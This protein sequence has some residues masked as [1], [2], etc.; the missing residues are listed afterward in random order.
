MANTASSYELFSLMIESNPVISNTSTTLTLAGTWHNDPEVW[1]TSVSAPPPASS[2]TIL[3][4]G[5]DQ[6]RPVY[7]DPQTGITLRLEVS[8]QYKQ[9]V[10]E[11]DLLWG[12][13][14]IRPELATRIAG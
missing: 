3:E 14:L 10:W 8:R 1:R 6:G 13:K 5:S 12:S 2:Y 7:L 9:V 4:P 11:F